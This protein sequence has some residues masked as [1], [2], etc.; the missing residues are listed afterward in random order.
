MS[1]SVRG[2]LLLVVLILAFNY[3]AAD[4]LQD[5]FDQLLED[6]KRQSD[7]IDRM[8]QIKLILKNGLKTY[9]NP[10]SDN[11]LL[12]NVQ[13][14]LPDGFEHDYPTMVDML[15]VP[16]YLTGTVLKKENLIWYVDFSGV[17]VQVL[18]LCYYDSSTKQTKPDA[19]VPRIGEQANFF[20][21]FYTYDFDGKIPVFL[22]DITQTEYDMATN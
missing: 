7:I 16:Y 11:M 6:Y 13:L 20:I 2:L 10:A 21:T 4:T 8:E 14:S 22:L 1:K 3:A 18:A 5:E 9:P 19:V 17:T 12:E 15:G